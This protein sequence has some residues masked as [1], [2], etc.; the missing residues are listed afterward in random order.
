MSRPE[1]PGSSDDYDIVAIGASTGGD[2]RAQR[3]PAPCRYRSACPIPDHPASAHI[4]HAHISRHSWRYCPGQPCDVATDRLHPRPS[5]SIV[6]P[7]TRICDA[8]RCRQRRGDP[9]PLRPVA[10]GCLPSVDPDAAIGRR[11]VGSRALAI[12]LTAWGAT[13]R[14]GRNMFAMRAAVSSRRT[15]A[16]SV[17][18]EY[19]VPWSLRDSPTPSSRPCDPAASSRPGV[20]HDAR[21]PASRSRQVRVAD[22]DQRPHRAAQ[23]RVPANRSHLTRGGSRHPRWK[24]LRDRKLDTLDQLVTQL[25]G[26]SDRVIGDRIVDALLNQEPRSTAMRW[27]SNRSSGRSP[28]REP[29]GA[30][31]RIWSAGCATGQ[32]PLCWR[33]CSP[34]MQAQTGAPIPE[35][36]ATDGLGRGDRARARRPVHAVRSSAACRSGG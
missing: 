13:G 19:A 34:N 21:P 33:Y 6:A 35:I 14:R 18:W 29:R 31:S 15:R 25:L 4:V 24:M 5:R 28:T 22:C 12:M 20:S 36:V 30:L 7:A 2:P 27:C 8:S 17:V 11:G 10:N 32:E 1:R 16:S 23:K 9:A 26:G 3:T